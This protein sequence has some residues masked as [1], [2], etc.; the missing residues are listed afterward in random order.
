[1]K[2][3]ACGLV[4]AF[5]LSLGSCQTSDNLASETTLS[6]ERAGWQLTFSDNFDGVRGAKPNL[7]KWQSENYNRRDNPNGPDGWWDADNVRL[8]GEGNL[9]LSVTQIPNR[10]RDTDP[11]DFAAGMVSTKGLFEQR[12]G[13]FEMRGRLP[14]ETGWWAAFWLFSKGAADVGKRGRDGTEIDIMEGFG[15][16]DRLKHALHWDGAA[17]AP[18]KPKSKDK[19]L[20][21]PGISEG[22]H[23]FAL[24]W[25]PEG[26]VFFV[27]DIETWRTDAGGVSRVPAYLK[28]TAEISSEDWAQTDL[29]AG[30]INPQAYPDAFIIDYVKVWSR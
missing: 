15:G 24:E 5:G 3:K 19:T 26:Y 9:I 25:S 21:W 23:I 11:H 14:R 22:F 2:A 10:N 16:S 4:F 8:D 29:W 20:T 1:M 30:P 17:A 6:D 28:L 13:R 27:D 18:R 7:Q 12:Y